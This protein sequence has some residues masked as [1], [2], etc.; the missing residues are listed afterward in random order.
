MPDNEPILAR[1][2]VWWDRARYG[3]P[4]LVIDA[5]GRLCGLA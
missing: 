3:E 1:L 4:V 2:L 5:T